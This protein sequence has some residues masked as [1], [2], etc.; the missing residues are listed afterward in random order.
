MGGGVDRETWRKGDVEIRGVFTGKEAL[1][2][3]KNIR[4]LKRVSACF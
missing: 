3:K 4:I 1:Y 2:K